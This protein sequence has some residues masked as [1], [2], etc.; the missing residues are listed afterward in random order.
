LFVINPV[1]S[2]LL[3]VTTIPELIVEVKFGSAYYRIWGQTMEL[4][5]KRSVFNDL[6]RSPETITE[7]KLLGVIDHF[8]TKS[9]EMFWSFVN[10]EIESEK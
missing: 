2:L 1:F 3:I 5:R 6:F 4:R 7:V 9:A 8:L 10:L